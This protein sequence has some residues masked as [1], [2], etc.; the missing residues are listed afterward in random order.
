MCLLS[1]FKP[2]RITVRWLLSDNL[3]ASLLF[4]SLYGPD[5]DAVSPPSP[6][7]LP[8]LVLRCLHCHFS[9][10][11][12]AFAEAMRIRTVTCRL[13]SLPPSGSLCRSTSKRGESFGISRIGSKIKGVFKSTTMEGAMLPSY[14]LVEGEDDMVSCKKNIPFV[15]GAF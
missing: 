10:A 8:P 7:P 12:C 13:I 14:G 4:S 5:F 9:Q 1:A 3:A 15:C 6:T 2:R 11:A